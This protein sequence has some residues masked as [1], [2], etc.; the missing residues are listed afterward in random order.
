MHR[1]FRTLFLVL[2]VLVAATAWPGLSRVSGGLPEARAE[3]P[4]PVIAHDLGTA[5]VGQPLQVPDARAVK[6]ELPSV[7]IMVPSVIMG[8]TLSLLP[9]MD[10][11]LDGASNLDAESL[12]L[13]DN[14]GRFRPFDLSRLTRRETG[15]FWLRF[16]I[17]PADA[18]NRPASYV[19]D[20]GGPL[21]GSPDFY[22]STRDAQGNIA[23]QERHPGQR[24]II[25]LPEAG[26]EPVACLL[27]LKGVPG[28]W[29]APLLRTPQNAATT[30]ASL[31]RVAG[32]FL[33][34]T[35]V[36]ICLLRALVER[37]QWRLWAIL[38][39]AA[40]LGQAWL[41][42]PN[43][44]EGFTPKAVASLM[45]PGIALMLL[46]HVGRHLMRTDQASRWLDIQFVILCLPGAALAALPFVPNYLWTSGYAECWPLAMLIFVPSTIGALLCGR[47][48]AMRFLLG[49]LIPP[50]AVAAAILG[51]RSG[52]APQLLG[53]LPLWG[54]ALGA[55]LV[56][57]LPQPDTA[58]GDED[59][60][61]SERHGKKGRKGEGLSLDLAPAGGL[62]I[63][64]GETPA[65]E[66]PAMVPG[67]RGPDAA[68]LASDLLGPVARVNKG[69][70]ALAD[71]PDLPPTA[72]EKVH[73]LQDTITDVNRA[74]L[75]IPAAPEAKANLAPMGLKALVEAAQSKIG[76]KA[77][78][79]G[80]E[81]SATID[82]SLSSHY[83]GPAAE[84]RQVLSG[85]LGDLVFSAAKGEKGA[86]IALGI[87]RKAQAGATA[88]GQ[89]ADAKAANGT[90]PILFTISCQG[91]G[92]A[93]ASLMTLARARSL[94]RACQG[95]L[96]LACHGGDTALELCLPLAACAAPAAP[97]PA[98]AAAA[99][100]PRNREVI[101]LA[102]NPNIAVQILSLLDRTD[103]HVRNAASLDELLA[104]HKERRAMMLVLQGRPATPAAAAT[105][106]GIRELSR[107]K[108]TGVPLIL[109]YTPD[110]TTWHDLAKAGFTHALTLPVETQSFLS[111]VD[112]ACDTT[113][114][115]TG[116]AG[117]A[118]AAEPEPEVEE[119]PDLFG[120]S[121]T[122]PRRKAPAAAAAP[123]AA[124]KQATPSKPG[125]VNPFSEMLGHL[126]E[127]GTP[128]AD[129]A[130]VRPAP[131]KAPVQ[132]APAR[133]SAPAETPAAAGN[134]ITPELAKKMRATLENAT[135]ALQAGNLGGV[136]SHVTALIGAA[137]IGNMPAIA[138]IAT[139]VA[140]AAREG[141]ESAV[142]DLLPEL[143]M[144]LER[145]FREN[146]LRP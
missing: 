99:R 103:C 54:T 30:W 133:A 96:S 15:S 14:A 65:A 53:A 68:T 92:R 27:R 146:G 41:G 24:G 61:E 75:A 140:Q 111:T 6:P 94:A 132:A 85:L 21:P 134:G 57:G 18:G 127:S 56:V 34:A 139:L 78:E 11:L 43:T 131:A 123:K 8:D 89:A 22:F 81:L 73:V 82:P 77:A 49:C 2:L 10:Y 117:A 93:E 4:F 35:L 80:I 135:Q 121:P 95:S 138:R 5:P 13:P 64:T 28:S 69:L 126:H 119:I 12:L 62:S 84:L 3:Q 100:G 52:L 55:L 76:G 33:L 25:L 74:L 145:K 90:Q 120:S 40:V 46:P 102:D 114:R 32:M 130:A 129:T 83:E 47:A 98:A 107:T 60:E 86:R 116:Q 142:S 91:L 72:R 128:K 58:R 97:S 26:A 115:L 118:T 59:E 104:L 141:D 29:F 108:E 9:Y 125:S 42:L 137:A 63:D 67:R 105:L 143:S 122:P 23:W 31:Y 144:A 20:L 109:A 87:G 19:V 39:L 66:G 38:Y 110:K 45:L 48:G 70:A 7:R 17:A 79:K 106:A 16:V 37:G 44:A 1:P 101:L 113:D 88:A 71:Q 50:A 124:P 136:T 112:E 51:G 36:L